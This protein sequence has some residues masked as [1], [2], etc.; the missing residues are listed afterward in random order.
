MHGFE[1]FKTCSY[2][3]VIMEKYED[4]VFDLEDRY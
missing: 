2:E 1:G 3:K 4:G